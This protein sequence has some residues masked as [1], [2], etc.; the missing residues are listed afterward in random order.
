[1]FGGYINSNTLSNKIFK[2]RPNIKR[3]YHE[4][5]LEEI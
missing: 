1:M 4:F 3:P 5:D 2:I